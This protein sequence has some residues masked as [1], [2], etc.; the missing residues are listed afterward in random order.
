MQLG[1]TQRQA[2][3][4]VCAS[5]SSNFTTYHSRSLSL[6][7]FSLSFYKKYQYSSP[8][9]LQEQDE[10]PELQYTVTIFFGA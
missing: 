6:Y 1:V 3:N 7:Q 5:K 8:E 2:I 4:S 9:I 10:W